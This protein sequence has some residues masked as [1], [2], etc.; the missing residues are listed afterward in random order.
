VGPIHRRVGRSDASTAPAAS[1]SETAWAR[2]AY[3]DLQHCDYII[4]DTPGNDTHLA[5]VAH[6]NADILITPIN[7]S[8]LDID[9]L[10]QLDTTKREV[11]G[12]GPYAQ[13]VWEQGK[14]R[15]NAEL[16]PTDWIVMRNRL[17]HI[18]SRQQLEITGLL[19]TL[20]ERI[21]FR[22]ATGFG[23]RVVFREMFLEGMTLLDLDPSEL[24]NHRASSRNAARRELGELL[25]TIGISAP[26]SRTETPASAA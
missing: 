3:N 20:S 7:D 9:I 21:G 19:E 22:L 24:N 13:M 5:R 15:D 10:A 16:P 6:L 18:G 12:P 8:L 25:Q 11:S 2:G 14:R 26:R 17:S 23:E 4:V 1:A